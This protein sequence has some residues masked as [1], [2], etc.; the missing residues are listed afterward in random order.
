MVYYKRSND[1]LEGGLIKFLERSEGQAGAAFQG[2]ARSPCPPGCFNRRAVGREAS[3]I[4]CFPQQQGGT[5]ETREEAVA[6]G[7]N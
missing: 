2:T 1:C 4:D 7:P 6:F 3:D 5:R